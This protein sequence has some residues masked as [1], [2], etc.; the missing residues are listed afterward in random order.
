MK[1]SNKPWASVKPS[2]YTPEQYHQAC[3]VHNHEPGNPSKDACKLPIK[4]P[5]GTVNANGVMAATRMLGKTD[6]PAAEKA[7]AARNLAG[8]H[9]K[10]NKN[11][12][13]SLKKHAK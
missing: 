11:V 8:M 6:A 2:S 7:K 10:M 9:R 1:V 3:L 12:P 5:D 13:D 4:E